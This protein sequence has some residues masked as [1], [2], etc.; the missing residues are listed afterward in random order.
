MRFLSGRGRG[1]VVLCVFGSKNWLVVFRW[2]AVKF[3]TAVRTIRD[4]IAYDSTH[5]GMTA[6]TSMRPFTGTLT[7]F[8][9]ELVVSVFAVEP[10]VADL[11]GIKK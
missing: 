3:V 2:R 8:T 11:Q 6:G 4:A 1:M 7:E 10:T 5:T 9:L